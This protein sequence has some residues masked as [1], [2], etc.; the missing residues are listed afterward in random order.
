MHLFTVGEQ[1]YD[2]AVSEQLVYVV[3]VATATR[4]DWVGGI[5]S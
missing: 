2:V 5:G 1:F 4:I 3:E